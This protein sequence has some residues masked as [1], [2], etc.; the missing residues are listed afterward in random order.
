MALGKRIVIIGNG[1]AAGRFLEELLARAPETHD[2]ILF[3]AEPR[4]NYSRIMLSPVLAGE[5]RFEDIVIHD[6]DWYAGHRINLRK[7][8][9]VASIDRAAKRVVAA[10]GS[11]E[12]YDALVVATGS[13]PIVI[14][15]PGVQLPGVVTYRDLDDVQ[16]MLS[17]ATRPGRRAVVIGG[18]LLGLEAAAGL[19]TRGMEVSVLHLMPHL[20]ER[21]LD[22]A[23]GT[24]LQSALEAR[25]I[26][27]RTGADTAAILGEDRV[28]GVRLKD[29]TEIAAD[30]VVMAVGI[31]PHA[32]LAKVAGLA[33][34]RGVVVDDAMRTN[35]RAVYAIGECVEHRGMS[36]GL[37][38]PLYDMAKVAAA[39]I[40]GDDAELFGRAATTTKLKVTG[41]DLFSAG[42][43]AS[44][45]HREDIVVE[46]APLGIYKRLVI[47]DNRIVGAVLYGDT[48]D[49]PF[50]SD[51][52]QRQTDVSA[53]RDVVMFGEAYA[54]P[55]MAAQ[56]PAVQN[57]QRLAA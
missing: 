15:I 50:F 55:S 49:G 14:P 45:P 31:R 5:K 39:Q 43:F 54:S 42:D 38:A 37:V 53:M 46:A 29:G 4:V 9:E 16:F 44:A 20:M 26:D 51:L 52:I 22:R 3:G 11:S 32:R 24:L 2:I 12:S 23:A 48:A 30:L 57:P 35:D 21:Q 6:D 25:G 7:G 27:V 10:D 17:A 1:M 56:P 18:G 41:I 28:T 36:Y 40:V 8:V 13:M 47:E 19:R 33:T 34:N